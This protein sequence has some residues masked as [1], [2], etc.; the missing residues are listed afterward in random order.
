LTIRTTI[1]SLDS[2]AARP[3]PSVPPPPSDSKSD[4]FFASRIAFP[5]PWFVARALFLSDSS[6]FLLAGEMQPHRQR[7]CCVGGVR[8][9]CRKRDGNALIMA[10]NIRV[11]ASTAFY[12]R[13]NHAWGS[14]GHQAL[15]RASASSPKRLVIPLGS[16]GPSTSPPRRHIRLVFETYLEILCSLGSGLLCQAHVR[17]YRREAKAPH[18]A[19]RG[20]TGSQDG[21]CGRRDACCA[22]LLRASVT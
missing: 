12:D 16:T 11:V 20:S 1:C 18:N 3:P 7:P 19:D 5:Y 14:T 9:A 2:F 8:R 17:G 21:A 15:V 13:T 10:P 22:Q 6:I 4:L